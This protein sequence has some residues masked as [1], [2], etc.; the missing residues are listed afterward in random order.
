LR[1]E[2]QPNPFKNRLGV[3]FALPRPGAVLLNVYDAAGRHVSTLTNGNRESGTHAVEWNGYDKD[4][5]AATP[6]IYF[7]RME[8]QDE[9][10]TARS[11]LL[12]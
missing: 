12:R 7:V 10:R 8:T 9:V 3:T 6:G 1:L 2:V 5:N 11:V 4:G